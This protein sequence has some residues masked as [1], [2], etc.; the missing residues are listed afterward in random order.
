VLSAVQRSH[1]GILRASNVVIGDRESLGGGTDAGSTPEGS[2]GPT[3]QAVE[4]TYTLYII[5]T[6]A[7]NRK[8]VL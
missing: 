4:G 2:G 7:G 1:P 6:L 5:N 3:A 8:S